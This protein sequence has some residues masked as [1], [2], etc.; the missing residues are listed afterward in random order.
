MRG[1]RETVQDAEGQSLRIVHVAGRG[2]RWLIALVAA[3]GRRFSRSGFAS[4]TAFGRAV[5]HS[6]RSAMN[7]A[8][9]ECLPLRMGLCRTAV[10]NYSRMACLPVEVELD[11]MP[12]A[13][14][15][16]GRDMSPENGSACIAVCEYKNLNGPNSL[17]GIGTLEGFGK[18]R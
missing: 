13:C 7:G 4:T 18:R 17:L 5:S 16:F 15:G 8:P 3:G 1:L 11:G 14:V 6:S 10:E 9:D 12:E 2:M